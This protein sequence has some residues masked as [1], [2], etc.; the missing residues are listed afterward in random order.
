MKIPE[1]GNYRYD[2]S[3]RFDVTI[4]DDLTISKSPDVVSLDAEE[5]RFPLIVRSVETGDRFVPFGMTGHKLVSDYLTDRK[6]S[7][8]E[9]RRQ[10]VM[11]DRDGN[12][13]WLVGQRVDHH[14]RITAQ[15]TKVLRIVIR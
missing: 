3:M 4:T 6:L 11:T 12:I 8:L 2:E 7:V 5:V 10:L 9:K 1:P 13:L 14:Y 15:T